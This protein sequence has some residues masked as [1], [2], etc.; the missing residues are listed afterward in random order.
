[1]SLVTNQFNF[2]MLV[3]GGYCVSTLLLGLLATLC[4]FPH[5]SLCI[6]ALPSGC[7]NLYITTVAKPPLVLTGA[8]GTVSSVYYPNNYTNWMQCDWQITSIWPTGVSIVQCD[9]YT[10]NVLST[11]VQILECLV[12]LES[13]ARCTHNHTTAMRAGVWLTNVQ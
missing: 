1:V 5:I 7:I 4:S 6:A 9:A 10:M 13:H 8:T 2:K 11:W 12:L 3:F